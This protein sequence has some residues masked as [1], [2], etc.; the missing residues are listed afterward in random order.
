[1]KRVLISTV[2]LLSILLVTGV[3]SA[4]RRGGVRFGFF[5][6]PPIIAVPAPV[7]P[8]PYYYPPP[9]PYD[10]GYR[11]WVPGHWAEQWGPYGWERVW[12][13]GHWR[14]DR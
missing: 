8:I 1:M 3:A 6:G 9:P 2:I 10:Y 4:H 5:F 7:Y 14:Y 13:P 11:E 12:I